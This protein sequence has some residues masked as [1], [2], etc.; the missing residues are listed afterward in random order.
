MKKYNAPKPLMLFD[1]IVIWLAIR[2]TSQIHYGE[3][4][5]VIFIINMTR[6]DFGTRCLSMSHLPDVQ[7][8]HN[9][10]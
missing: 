2:K 6:G 5:V 4:Q 7:Q 9:N 1:G 3:M 8:N 10:E